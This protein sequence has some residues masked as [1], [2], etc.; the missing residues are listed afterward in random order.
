M[1]IG[2]IAGIRLMP[3]LRSR[4]ADPELTAFAEIEASARPE[5]DSYTGSEEKGADAEDAEDESGG[6]EE[7]SQDPGAAAAPDATPAG[8]VNFFA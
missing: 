1:E 2:P 5:E 7:A 6:Q 3:G 4:P 8:T